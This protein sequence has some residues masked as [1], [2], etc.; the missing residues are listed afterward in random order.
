M[1]TIDV[2]QVVVEV[3]TEFTESSI[4]PTPPP[5]SFDVCSPTEA[6]ANPLPRVQRVLNFDQEIHR[7]IQLKIA[8]VAPLTLYGYSMEFVPVSVSELTNQ[9]NAYAA[10]W[11]FNEWGHLFQAYIAYIS[12]DDITWNI[13]VDDAAP[14]SYTLPNSNGAFVKQWVVL[15]A[16]KGK[17]FNWAFSCAEEMQIIVSQSVLL[18]KEFKTQGAYQQLQCFGDAT[19]GG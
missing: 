2:T 4:G 7:N 5:D 12:T 14:D 16:R 3:L 6:P 10:S 9:R 18:A 8:A 11:T 17:L 19:Y 15:K 1:S 13:T